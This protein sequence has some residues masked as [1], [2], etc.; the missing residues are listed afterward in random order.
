MGSVGRARL[1]GDPICQCAGRTKR[2]RIVDFIFRYNFQVVNEASGKYTHHMV[3]AFETELTNW[4][5]LDLSF[6]W[7]RIQEPQPDADGNV[8][9]Q[10]DYYFIFGLGID[11]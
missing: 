11:I 3:T 6:V 4:L 1:S 10:D 7:D 9:E 2:A 8:P 5:D